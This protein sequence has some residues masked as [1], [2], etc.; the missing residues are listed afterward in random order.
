MVSIDKPVEFDHTPNAATSN[1][2]LELI[3]ISES[4]IVLPP[5]ASPSQPPSAT[6]DLSQPLVAQDESL[7]SSSVTKDNPTALVLFKPEQI[8]L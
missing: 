2:I 1:S 4:N 6:N 7:N 8:F 3:A 5:Q